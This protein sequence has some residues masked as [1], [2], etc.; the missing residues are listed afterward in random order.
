MVAPAG[1]HKVW[2]CLKYHASFTNLWPSSWV[3]V[4]ERANG[5]LSW[6]IDAR[7]YVHTPLMSDRPVKIHY[8]VTCAPFKK[9]QTEEG[10]K[11]S[12]KLD[13]YKFDLTRYSSVSTITSY[14]AKQLV[15]EYKYVK[16]FTI[17]A[18]IYVSNYT[19]ALVL[20][21]LIFPVNN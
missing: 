4:K 11:D 6:L 19:H 17:V 20:R 14:V 1:D 2:P 16:Y 15:T 21:M 9:Y 5:P 3:I 13:M 8:D 18:K 7:Q 12:W 10:R